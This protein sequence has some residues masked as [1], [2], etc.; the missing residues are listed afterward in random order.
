[1]NIAF[2]AATTNITGRTLARSLPD[3]IAARDLAI[4][5]LA[6][7]GSVPRPL[8]VP[9]AYKK[10]G[11]SVVI[12]VAT[13]ALK[14][15]TQDPIRLTVTH[16]TAQKL[17]D[18]FGA[19]L[20]TT[21]MADAAYSSAIQLDPQILP[22]P[23][24]S[25]TAQMIH[26]SDLV[27]AEIERHGGKPGNIVR[28]LGKD[29]VNTE[30]LLNEDGSIAS[31]TGFPGTIAEAN[32]GMHK[33]GAG[34]RSPGGMSV[35]QSVGLAH[36]IH[37]TDYSQVT[38]L[39]GLVA[40]IDGIP[41]LIATA[42]RDPKLAYLLSDEIKKGQVARVWRHPAVNPGFTCRSSS[43]VLPKDPNT[44]LVSGIFATASAAPSS[45]PMPI[46]KI[47]LACAGAIVGWLAV[48][49]RNDIRRAIGIR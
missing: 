32:F 25:S 19:M 8:F 3:N 29:W 42:M 14:I 34:S 10:D 30:R 1:M 20:P 28:D 44:T 15:G 47:G 6:E 39:Y 38:T 16:P 2:G 22:V 46:G 7:M 27:N 41:V 12:E 13:D 40:I 48:K 24:M 36:D 33:L 21:R 49:H 43:C 45:N 23:G 26:A 4:L 9:L 11:H 37:H 18:L 5:A 31:A 35:I 17:A